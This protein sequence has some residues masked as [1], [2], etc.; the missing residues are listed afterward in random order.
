MRWRAVVSDTRVRAAEPPAFRHDPLKSTLVLPGRRGAPSRWWSEPAV[1]GHRRWSHHSRRLDGPVPVPICATPAVVTGA[2]VLAGG[3]DGR[4]RFHN[5]T[6]DRV[7]WERRL[8]GPIYAS[9]VVD[10]ARR[11]IVVATTG[12]TVACFDLRGELAW[13]VGTGLPIHA[14]PAVLPE[15]DVLVVAGFGSR[16][17]GLDLA[18]GATIFARDLPR[19]WHA[20]YGGSAAHRDPYASPVATASG[21]AIVCCAEHVLCLAPDGTELWRLPLGRSVRS[22]PVALHTLGQV[23]VCP[24]DGGCVFLDND[25]GRERGVVELGG[26]VVASPAVSGHIMAVGT[27]SGDAFGIDIRTRAVVWRAAHGAPHDHTSFTV[28]PDGGFVATVSRGNIV[29]LARDDGRFRWETSQLLGLPDLDPR[30]DI[31][32]VVGMDG[33]MYCGSYAGALYHFRFAPAIEESSCP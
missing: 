17:L 30:L 8:D 5:R 14:T 15:A 6:L 3:Y 32:P 31:T 13:S 19:P 33:S 27:Q 20:G 10:A 9:L 23:A 11:R 2:G 28:T 16:C 25:T 7:Y 24:V 1:C 22:S 12:G 26:K 21:N 29:G 4:V 18:T